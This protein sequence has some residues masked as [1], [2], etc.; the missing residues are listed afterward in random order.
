PVQHRF[1]NSIPSSQCMTCHMHPGTNMEATYFGYT[2]WDNE[3]DGAHMY[4]KTPLKLTAAQQDARERSNPEGAA[5]RGLWGDR[6]FLAD[7]SKL[8]PQLEHTQFA[9]FNGHGWVF[10]AVYKKDRKGNLLDAKDQVVP[11][12]APDKFQK[13]VHL[14]DI[15]LE[16]GMH[17]VDCHFKQDNHGN[18]NLYN[19]P[20][21]AIEIT[22]VDCHGSLKRRAAALIAR[23]HPSPPLISGPFTSGPAAAA[24]LSRDVMQRQQANKLIETAKKD[25]CLERMVGADYKEPMVGYDLK[26]VK[27]RD[28]NDNEVALFEVIRNNNVK[29]PDENGRDVLLNKGDIIQHS[30]VVAGRWWRVVQTMDTVT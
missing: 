30:M 21:A 22:C 27:V 7:V 11:D 26:R 18:G 10:R 20:R 24:V 12:S 17:C 29:R 4:P 9:D 3:V 15:H 25:K 8:N 2:W 19:E 14:Q 28:K 1:T 23:P 6:D 5:L 16:K 13:A